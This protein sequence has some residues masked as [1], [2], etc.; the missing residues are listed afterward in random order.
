[1]RR[2]RKTIFVQA[3]AQPLYKVA[4]ALKSL[5]LS[6]QASL[7][8]SLQKAFV[9]KH[10]ARPRNCIQRARIPVKAAF[11]IVAPAKRHS[12]VASDE[13]RLFF[14]CLRCS[15][16]DALNMHFS[17]LSCKEHDKV[18]ARIVWEAFVC[19]EAFSNLQLRRFWIQACAVALPGKESLARAYVE[20]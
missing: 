11:C 20:E 5:F 3:S 7:P 1:M 2:A 4:L 6:V 9:H 8:F 18:C 13:H 19:I 10:C 16:L 14:H 12:S 17:F 15:S